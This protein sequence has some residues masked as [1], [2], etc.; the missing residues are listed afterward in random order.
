MVWAM[1]C[2]FEISE[3]QV[4]GPIILDGMEIARSYWV[5]RRGGFMT[6]PDKL[7]LYEAG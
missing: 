1:W 6:I 7:L 4:R 3:F 2:L 5:I